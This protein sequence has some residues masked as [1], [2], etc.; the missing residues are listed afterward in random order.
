MLCR[1]TSGVL[2]ERSGLLMPHDEMTRPPFRD[3]SQRAPDQSETLLQGRAGNCSGVGNPK[4]A[5]N[6]TG[7]RSGVPPRRFDFLMGRSNAPGGLL[8][9]KLRCQEP[10]IFFGDTRIGTA[11]AAEN[12]ATVM[13]MSFIPCLYFRR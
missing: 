1:I 7:S 5:Q 4:I 12:C 3:G 2:R 9:D 11:N 10:R 6:L 8:T 13:P